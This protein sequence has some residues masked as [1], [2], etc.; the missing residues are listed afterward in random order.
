MAKRIIEGSRAVVTGASSGIGR[1]IALELARCGAKLIVVARSE[2]KLRSLAD[3]ICQSGQQA[4]PVVGDITEE[5]V[6][7][8]VVE[9]AESELG[10]LDILV[11]N[12]GVSAHGRFL[13]ASPDRLRRIMEVNFFAAAE[14]I[15]AALP[16][17]QSGRRPM[18][19]NV[20]SI[21]GHRGLPLNTEYCASKFA[22]QGFSES[23]RAEFAKLGIDVL[24]VSPGTTETEMFDH[25][26]E[27]KDEVPWSLKRG[28]PAA[29]VARQ[30]VR[31]IRL[32]K[33]EITPSFQ[34]RMLVWLNRMAPRLVDRIMQRYG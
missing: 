8:E 22:L 12:A 32:G 25:L 5:A 24:V 18:V 3:Q 31:A 10:G 27:Q 11:N 17:L 15:R 33:H 29:H 20:G 28:V 30:T 26:I 23:L 6:R 1:A 7:R 13:T 21:L 16:L 19:V 4:V 2:D 9:R 14:L 34:G